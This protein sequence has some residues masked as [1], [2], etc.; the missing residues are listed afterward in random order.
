M[1]Q[2][3]KSNVLGLKRNVDNVVY[4]P[5][6]MSFKRTL[7][8]LLK[9]TFTLAHNSPKYPKHCQVTA[10]KWTRRICEKRTQHAKLRK[11]CT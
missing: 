7:Y 8:L 9:L 3:T 11:L 6:Y 4:A 5:D 2:M 10:I 1:T